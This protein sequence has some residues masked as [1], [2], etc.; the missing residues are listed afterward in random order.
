M[1]SQKLHSIVQIIPF[2]K[3]NRWSGCYVAETYSKRRSPRMTDGRWWGYSE[4]DKLKLLP[5]ATNMLGCGLPKYNNV[6]FLIKNLKEVY[7]DVYIMKKLSYTG[8]N[9]YE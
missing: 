3:K 6:F 7:Y 9:M 5:Y 2:L 8:L 1:Y 4:L